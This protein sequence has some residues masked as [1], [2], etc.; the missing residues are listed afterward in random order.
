MTLECQDLEQVFNECFFV[1]YHTVL[2]GVGVE[3]LYLSSD[4]AS[5]VGSCEPSCLN[6]RRISC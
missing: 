6:R 2:V 1:D 4:D 3:P 5:F